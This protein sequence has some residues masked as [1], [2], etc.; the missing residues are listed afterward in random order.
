MYH[1]KKPGKIRVV[2][3][4]SAEFKEVSLNKNLMKGPDL[5]NQIVGV[6]TR[7]YEEPVVIVGAIEST[8]PGL[9][10]SWVGCIIPLEI[11]KYIARIVQK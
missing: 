7:F 2:F 6:L 3:D 5:T 11:E 10:S 4:C 9:R 1:P 8:S